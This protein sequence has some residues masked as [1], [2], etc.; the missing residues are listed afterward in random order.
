[1]NTQN[2]YLDFFSATYKLFMW[3]FSNFPERLFSSPFGGLLQEAAARHKIG[4]SRW[5]H[6]T[7]VVF[8][9][10]N[11]VGIN[12]LIDTVDMMVMYE[13]IVLDT[14][15]LPLRHNGNQLTVVT[16]QHVCLCW[17]STR[18][19]SSHK[20]APFLLYI[21]NQTF[22]ILFENLSPD[23]SWKHELCKLRPHY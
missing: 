14:N 7:S 23:R 22:N 11:D 17:S 1:M 9:V 15:G 18:F 6:M 5:L 4:Q 3:Q 10:V 19:Q 12:D 13:C 20:F 21:A 2:T 8:P 16:R